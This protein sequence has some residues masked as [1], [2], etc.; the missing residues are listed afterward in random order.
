M[1]K[2]NH[3]HCTQQFS[4]RVDCFLSGPAYGFGSKAIPACQMTDDN[5]D[6]IKFNPEH[7][8]ELFVWK[9]MDI[10]NPV[11]KDAFFCWLVVIF[12]AQT[13]SVIGIRMTLH[14]LMHSG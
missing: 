9:S 10:T 4:V 12:Y 8:M 14:L 11:T 1:I 6:H 5:I 3:L 13:F 7:L 2:A